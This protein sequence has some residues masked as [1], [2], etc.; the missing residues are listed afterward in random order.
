MK[1]IKRINLTGSAHKVQVLLGLFTRALSPRGSRVALLAMMLAG[2]AFWPTAADGQEAAGPVWSA[3]MTVVEYSSVSIGAA[4]A[5]LFSNVGGSGNL[6]IKSLWSHIPDRDLRLAFEESVPNAADYTLQVGGLSLEFP[7][8]SSGDRSFKWNDVDVNWQDGQLIRVRIVPTAESDAQQPNTPAT[9]VPTISGTAQAGETLA[10]DTSGIADADGLSDVSYAYQWIRT[11]G[12]TDAG[13]AG[14]TDSTYTLA[15]A[16]EGKTIKLKV[17]FI[18]DKGN[19]ETLTSAATAAVAA[20]PNS[21][22]TGLPT[23]SGTAQAGQTLTAD[24]SDITDANGLTKV[25]YSYRWIRND[26]TNDSSIRGQTGSTYTLTDEDVGKSIKVKVYFTD[27]ADNKDTLTSAA[28]AAVAARPNSPATGLPTISGTAQVD[29][30]LTADTSGI[31]DADGLTNVTYSYQWIRNDGTNDSDI[32]GQTGSTYTLVSADEGKSVK[33]RVSFTDDRDNEETLTGAATAAVAAAPSRLTV[34]LENAASTHDGSAV[35]TFEIRFSEELSLSYTTLKFRAFDVTGG[36]V[37]NARRMDRPSNIR[38]LITVRP[39]SNGDVT[40]VLPV[41]EDCAAQG[42]ICTEDG[43]PLSN[44]LEMTV[45]GPRSADQNTEA[46]GAPTIS[47]TAQVDETLTADVS[48]ISDADGLSNV[49]YSYQWIR[50]DGTNDADIG[51]QTGSTYTLVSADVGKSIKV[52][53]TFTD[54]YASEETQTSAATDTVV[55][56]P[57]SPATGELT[58]S[59]TAQAGETLTADISGIAD[60]DGLDNA[61]FSYQWI[62]TDGGTDADIAGATGSTYTLTDDDEGKTINVRVWFIDDKGN[63]ETLNSVAL[64]SNLGAGVSGAGG[65]QRT[66]YAARSGFAQAFTTGT[67]TGGYP[68]GYVGIQVSHFYDGSTVGDHLRVTINGVAS[69]GEPGEA[70]CTLTNPSSFSTP[71]VSAFDAPTGA[72]SCPQL[73]AETTYFVVIEWV[74][75]SGTDSFAL[76]PQT[77]PTEKS[78]ATEEDPGGAEGWSIADQSY[79][80]TVSSKDRTWTAYDETASFKIKVKEAA[81]TA[82][83]ANNPATGLP[84]ISGTAQVGKTLTADT[85]PIADEDGLTNATFEY[86][87]IRNDGSAD[88]DIEDATDSTY[89]P[90]VSDVGKTIQVKVTFTDDAENAESL[91][92]EATDAVAAKPNSEA[93]GLPTITGTPQVDETLTASTSAINDEDGLEDIS[94]SYQ[95]IRSDG[96]NDTDIPDATDT[97][98]TLTVDDVGKTIQVRVTFTDDAENEETLTSVA[99]EAVDATVPTQPLSLTVATGD[100]TQKLD[101]SWQAPSSNGGSDVTG[102]KVQWKESADSWETPTEVSEATVTGTVHTIT[103][104]TDGVEY[105]VRVSAVND[106]GQ[107][108]CST[109]ASGTP[110][111]A[112]IW[113]ATLTVGTAETF[114][115]YTTFLT[116]GESNILGALLADTFTSDNDS[117][118]VKALGVLDGKL[119]L[120][121]TPKL[122]SGFVLMAGTTEFASTDASTRVNHSLIQ[123]LWTDS[124]LDWS[125]VEE[126]AVRLTKS[127]EDSA[128]TGAPTISGTPQVEQ[129]LTASTSDIDDEDGLTNVSYEYQWIAG[130]SDIDGATG[131]SHTLTASEQGKTIQVKVTF[132]DDAENAESLTSEATDAV[133]AKPNSEATGLPTITG[134]PQVDETLTASTSPINDEDGLEDVSYSYQWIRNDGSAD[135]DI[136]DATDS[137]YTPS[138]SDVGKT[139]QVKVTFTDD[140][141]NAESL[142]SEATDAVAAKPNSEATGLPTITGT[143]QVDETLTASTSAIND[144]DGLEDISY[145]Y[146]WIR[147]DGNNDTDIPDATDT[148]YTLTVDDVGKTIQVRVTFTDDAENEE[149]LTSVATEAVDATVPTQPLSLTVATGDQTQELDASWQAPSSNGGSDV[150]GYKVQWKE[151]ADSWDTAADVSEAAETGTTYTITSLTGGV[152]YAVRVIASNDVGDGPAS[153][154]AKGTPAGG[155]SEQVVEP[156]N[157][158]PT[159][160]PGISGTPQVDQT[161]TADTSPIDDEDGL[162][163]VSYRYQWIGG[164]SDIDGATGSSHTLT[165]SEQGKTIQVKVTFTDDRNNAETLTSIAT[166]PVAAAPEPL[167]VRLK[168]AAPATHDGSAEFTF[169]IEFSEEFGI[170]YATLRDHAFN[171]TGGSV[172]T[173]QRTDKPSNIPW[174]ITVKPQGNGDVTIELPATADCG[175]TGAICTGDGRK[176][177]NSLSFTVSG[178][179]Q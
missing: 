175:A 32:G 40:V 13:I 144:E 75:P 127:D 177:S 159:G 35:F 112:A 78:D 132:T 110:Q 61:E 162:T 95:W 103:G 163:N 125:D 18:D 58:I 48:T 39:D 69:E 146:Q 47:G 34:S 46:T 147:S 27:D 22:A 167:T 142:T 136:E 156:E 108:P 43:R 161:L 23:I 178:P 157:S 86:Q 111:E 135:T 38:W 143:P 87:W 174:L 72:G 140:A 17:W 123:F 96:N 101:A 67:K 97:T 139:I 54:D 73:A 133:A 50:N 83:K 160:L 100:Q 84:T 65:I 55:A 155:V 29:E 59:G 15:D 102:Y 134:T 120:S 6:Q 165:A 85:S 76:I 24:T 173:A 99:T 153:T 91:T 131:S 19:S 115:G 106:V 28:T 51:G 70:H 71:G 36:E 66:L 56:R 179:G 114:A 126:V 10:A 14:A 41:T 137:T 172:E 113:S 116:S 138:V 117:Y 7:E 128:A 149:T 79:Y 89:T 150:T 148:T 98:Y 33:V 42:A 145:S 4:S 1:S 109:E 57:N 31:T 93:T 80:L 60:A 104:L 11:D 44:R 81:V 107:G 62:R 154:E 171:V 176:L 49:S 118:T 129:T 77:Y 25:S 122:I 92:S 82:A 90:S 94:Y 121:V 20:R 141:E 68:L 124:G 53:V 9:G 3:D 74:D 164:G 8:D 158:A 12:G 2:M 21:P 166:A 16:D 37:L 30:T 170:S 105:S 168:A 169:E 45:T 5:D 52:R 64:V 151:S 88:T 130:G 119:I 152:E 26:G 63:S